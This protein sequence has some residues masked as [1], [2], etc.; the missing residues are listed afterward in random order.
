MPRVQQSELRAC[1]RRR[2]R[3]QYQFISCA[4]KARAPL[5]AKVLSFKRKGDTLN[6]QLSEGKIT[7]GEYNVKRVEILKP[8]ALALASITV[9]EEE[10]QYPA[11][12]LRQCRH[13]RRRKKKITYRGAVLQRP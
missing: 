2:L 1:Q 12:P 6:K 10:L 3:C 9:Y 4:R 8:M 11:K 7:F 13:M 5:L